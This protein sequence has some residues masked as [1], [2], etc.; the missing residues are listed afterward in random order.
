MYYTDTRKQ[1]IYLFDYDESTGV[2]GHQRVFAD[3]P[4]KAGEGHPD[5]MTVDAEGTVWSA[6]WDGYC[7]VRYTAQGEEMQRVSFPVPKVS[8]I[9]FG[10]EDYTDMYVTTAS[11]GH[12]EKDGPLAGALFHMNLGIRGVPEFRSRIGLG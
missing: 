7:L 9:T 1:K 12:R 10:G 6:R 5:G 2:V 3:V 11:G 8:C 4:V